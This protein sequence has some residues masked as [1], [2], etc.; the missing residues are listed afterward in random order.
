MKITRR[1]IREMIDAELSVTE[2]IREEMSGLTEVAQLYKAGE[3]LS[4]KDPVLTSQVDF[5]WGQYPQGGEYGGEWYYVLPGDELGEIQRNGDPFTYTKK[6]MSSPNVM[7]ASAPGRSRGAIGHVISLPEVW[8]DGPVM[9]AAEEVI[10]DV[11]DLEASEDMPWPDVRDNSPRQ[12]QGVPVGETIVHNRWWYKK[13]DS[14]ADDDLGEFRW[15]RDEFNPAGVWV[16]R[17]AD[18]G[19]VRYITR[20]GAFSSAPHGEGEVTDVRKM[21]ISL[22]YDDL[23]QMWKQRNRHLYETVTVT[24]SQIRRLILEAVN[25]KPP[26]WDNMHVDEKLEELLNYVMATEFQIFDVINKRLDALEEADAESAKE[27]DAV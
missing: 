12:T 16:G 24:R 6:G 13:L 23:E 18:R 3:G 8:D 1:L 25:D 7:V 14:L 15:G 26:G 21:G 19:I 22:D 10:P 20:D 4:Q 11:G 2:T 9:S 27:K 5:N 17:R